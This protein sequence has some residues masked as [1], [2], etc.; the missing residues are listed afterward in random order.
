MTPTSCSY[1]LGTTSGIAL[2]RI[3]PILATVTMWCMA[4]I[5]GLENYY[6]R[7]PPLLLLDTGI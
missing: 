3:D 7:L 6:H 2:E 4:V 1:V 5:P